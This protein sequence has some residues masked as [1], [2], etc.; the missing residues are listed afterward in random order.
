MPVSEV[1]VAGDTLK[2]RIASGKT[3]REIT[4]TRAGDDLKLTTA[5][6]KP[7]GTAGDA[8]VFTST[9]FARASL[10]FFS[11][12]AVLAPAEMP[13]PWIAKRLP[14]ALPNRIISP[15]GQTIASHDTSGRS[16]TRSALP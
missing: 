11:A 15:E 6:L 4:A 12:G 3:I 13:R 10:P 8:S 16:T 9:D 7:D 14:P 1:S 2:V 5:N